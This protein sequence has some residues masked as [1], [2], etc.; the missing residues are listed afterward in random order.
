MMSLTEQMRRGTPKKMLFL[1]CLKEVHLSF[2]NLQIHYDF[3]PYGI[4]S[5]VSYRDI[6]IWRMQETVDSMPARR[7]DYIK[8]EVGRY[9]HKSR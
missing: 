7:K 6:Y 5:Y 9:S 8:I 4:V 2:L 1:Y 3:K